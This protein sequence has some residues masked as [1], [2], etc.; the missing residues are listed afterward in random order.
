[1]V[2][3]F[4]HPAEQDVNGKGLNLILFEFGLYFNM[5]VIWGFLSGKIYKR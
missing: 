4:A 3:A 1:M 5:S 2:V